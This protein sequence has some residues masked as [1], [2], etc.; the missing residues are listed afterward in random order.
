VTSVSPCLRSVFNHFGEESFCFSNPSKILT[1]LVFR[2]TAILSPIFTSLD[3]IVHFRPFIF[4]SPCPTN[5]RACLLDSANPAL[6]TTLSSL[7]S[8]NF[9]NVSPVIPSCEAAIV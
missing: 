7:C 8:S 3:D 5:W 1:P 6:Y 2:F 4:I 9:S